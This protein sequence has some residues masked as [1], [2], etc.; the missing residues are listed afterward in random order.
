MHIPD[1]K[2]LCD[3]IRDG[4]RFAQMFADLIEQHPLLIYMSALPFTPTCTCLYTNFHNKVDYPWTTRGYQE[5]W[6]PKLFVFSGHSRQVRSIAISPD[7]TR[8][9]SGSAD[10]TIRVWDTMSGSQTIEPLLVKK[11]AVQLVA[12]STDGTLIASGSDDLTVRVWDSI[13]GALIVA[14]NDHISPIRSIAFSANGTRIFSI[15]SENIVRIWELA[16]GTFIFAPLPHLDASHTIS[17]FYGKHLV[18]ASRNRLRVWDIE[19]GAAVCETQPSSGKVHCM[20]LSPNGQRIVSCQGKDVV[21]WNASSGSKICRW[22]DYERQLHAIFSP[23]GMRVLSCGKSRTIYMREVESGAE[24][25]KILHAH[26]TAI[27]SL[28]FTPDGTRIISASTDGTVCVW[29]TRQ[30]V[31]ISGAES[32]EIRDVAS[33]TF[34]PCGTRLASLSVPMTL[35]VWRADSCEKV[36]SLPRPLDYMHIRLASQA[37]SPSGSRIMAVSVLKN[38]RIKIG[39]CD[40]R[41]GAYVSIISSTLCKLLRRDVSQLACRSDGHQVIIGLISEDEKT[42]PVPY[43]SPFSPVVSR[44]RLAMHGTLSAFQSFSFSL[45]ESKIISQSVDGARYSWDV[46][47]RPARKAIHIDLTPTDIT[48]HEPFSLSPDGWIES[49]TNGTCKVISKLPT[50][51]RGVRIRP[52]TSKSSIGVMDEGEQRITIIH[53][54]Q[55]VLS[56]M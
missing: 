51:L 3:I 17:A 32:R 46:S 54:P 42:A 16:S 7:G 9:V 4:Y 52:A 25:L 29:D 21:V 18:S 12:F 5:S 41:R 15:D 37:F 50:F 30:R 35:S 22:S 2:N 34:S 38:G 56:D 6:S 39:V 23:D 48:C 28:L 36:F 45:D 10:K 26:K 44:K 49:G 1:R 27:C 40:V 14:L 11:A 47:R 53:F 13:S 33:L 20:E 24:V 55:S 31:N 43:R 8:I 19:S